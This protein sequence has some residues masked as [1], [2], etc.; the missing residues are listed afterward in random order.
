MEDKTL[1]VIKIIEEAKKALIENNSFE[2]MQLSNRITDSSSIW[3]H[4]GD[5]AVIVIVYTLSKIVE[6]KPSLNISDLNWRKFINKISLDLDSTIS[7]L[8]KKN[9]TEY[10]NSLEKARKTIES[11]SPNIKTHIQEVFRKASITKASRLHE[12]GIS[13]EQTAKILGITQWELSEYVGKTRITEVKGAISLDIKKRA[14][15][16]LEFF[17]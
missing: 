12:H 8:E 5:L 7:A 14:R 13:L 17:T 9:F 16:A 15:I 1:H 6:R 4:K 3:Q 2:L 10:E 11:I